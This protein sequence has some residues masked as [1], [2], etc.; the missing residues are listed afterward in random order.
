MTVIFL[1]KKQ[2]NILNSGKSKH[3][4]VVFDVIDVKYTYKYW[5]AG[6]A[7]L[8]PAWGMDVCL[9]WV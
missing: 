8:K 3:V 4:N 1:Y 6:I 9:F 2:T 7:G 5:R